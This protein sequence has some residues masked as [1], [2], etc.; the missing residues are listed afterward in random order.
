MT[1]QDQIITAIDFLW[2]CQPGPSCKFVNSMHLAILANV[3]HD[4]IMAAAET[5][6]LPIRR[7]KYS[8]VEV[9]IAVD[10]R[11]AK[12]LA[13]HRPSSFYRRYPWAR[14][15]RGGDGGRFVLKDG[16]GGRIM[17]V[18]K[19]NFVS[20]HGS[21]K[22]QVAGPL[23]R[24][25]MRIRRPSREGDSWWLTLYPHDEALEYFKQFEKLKNVGRSK[26][27]FEYHLKCR[28]DEEFARTTSPPS[29]K[30]IELTC[31]I[32]D[33]HRW[34]LVRSPIAGTGR[35]SS[36]QEPPNRRPH[37]NIALKA[38]GKPIPVHVAPLTLNWTPPKTLTS[39]NEIVWSGYRPPVCGGQAVFSE[40]HCGWLFEFKFD[41]ITL[42][43]NVVEFPRRQVDE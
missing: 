13:G 19:L 30:V 24:P 41:G 12:W 43:A 5:I 20:I 10:H 36:L 7:G 2:R 17:D 9:E 26:L 1:D 22:R 4:A 21:P 33:D 34:V 39:F 8:D 25:R 31:M 23:D 42:G 3:S 35:K 37:L 18:Q 32:S 38:N 14:F 16:G 40:Q 11:Q 15:R 29:R 6:G 27:A 28:E